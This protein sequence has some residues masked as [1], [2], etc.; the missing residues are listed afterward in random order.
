MEL[1]TEITKKQQ[2]AAYPLNSVW[3]S[4]SAGSGKTKVLTDRVLNLLLQGSEPERLLCL[5]FTKAAA[6]EMANRITATLKKWA[7]ADDEELEKLL[8][9]LKG[10]MPTKEMLKLARA[11]F[12]KVLETP[13]GL[14]IMTI[15]S[16]CQSV[17]KRFPIEA[18]IP[19]QFE[20]IEET[21]SHALMH[22][23]ISETFVH[24]KFKKKAM[25]L[26]DYF[27]EKSIK[28]IF[29]MILQNQSL[30]D[31][32]LSSFHEKN[33]LENQLKKYFQIEKYQTKKEIINK[34]F[35]IEEFFELKN[36]YLTKDE[37]ILKKH[38]EEDK[39]HLVY[40]INQ[41][42]KAFDL[43]NVTCAITDIIA[44]I[45]KRY[46]KLKK[47]DSLLD[48]SDLI[49]LTRD[50]L[51]KSGMSQWV[52]YKLDGGIDHIL[53]DEAQDTN[54]EQWEIVRLI[55]EEFFSGLGSR[56]DLVR[57]IFAVGD[58][59]Q[60]IYSFQGADPNE[61][62]RMHQFF[63]QQ[64]KRSEKNFETVPLNVSFRSTA[65]VLDLVNL[66]LKNKKIKK[67][68]LNE[69]EE[70]VHTPFRSKDGG[71]VE[72]WPLEEGQEKESLINWSFPEPNKTPASATKLAQRIADKIS[73]MIGKEILPSRGTPIQAGDIMILVRSRNKIVSELVRALKERNIPVAGVDRIILTEHIAVQDL[74]CVARFALLPEDDL[75][76]ACLLKSPLFKLSEEDLFKL[77]HYR[78]DL[79]LYQQV[80]KEKQDI[81]QKLSLILNQADKMPV[82][83]FFS[84]LLGPL[85]GR[86]A[87]V[88][89]L[90]TEANEALDEFLSLTLHFEE[91]EIPTLQNFLKWISNRKVEIKRDLDQS[92]IDAVRIMTVHAS[93]GLQGNIVFLPDTRGVPKSKDTFLWTD[94]Q[95]PLWIA[96]AALKTNEVERLYEKLDE[97]EIEESNRLLYVALTRAKDRLYICGWDNKKKK[98]QTFTHNW[99]DL[100]CSSLPPEIK[101]DEDKIIRIFS[102]QLKEAEGEENQER[103]NKKTE[104]PAFVFKEAPL[105]T[106]LSKPLMPSQMED[107]VVETDTVLGLDRAKAMKRGTFIHQLLQYLPDIEP[108]KRKEVALRLKPDGIDIPENLFDVF[109]KEEF[110]HLFS[111]ESKAEVPIVGVVKNQVVSGQID[112]LIITDDAVLIVDFK[113]GKHVPLRE[114]FVPPLYIKQMMMYKELLKEIFP[115]KMIKTYLLWTENLSLMEL[116]KHDL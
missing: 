114:E 72:I 74:I 52:L 83:E 58:K 75:N 109:E 9:N 7:I 44:H 37:T 98:K 8:F 50:L 112:R 66:I 111:K 86:K 34:Y 51:K 43:V 54:P 32:R 6:A 91:T 93:K 4:A 33:N 104:L 12:V 106:A 25:L 20:V 17:L 45:L 26:S 69:N 40:E 68:L 23:A 101:P 90:G 31:E 21:K 3:V 36:K 29:D 65:A 5:T 84:Y 89:R 16:F 30:L 14:K 62:E 38:Q 48:Y 10:V 46:K 113:S 79:S 97:L 78:K 107:E 24:P 28:G 96:A 47:E 94:T 85:K 71:L 11:L 70:A 77:A 60:S 59:K 110:N 49:S 108:E 39:A 13:G 57:T 116:T 27:Y 22:Q 19:P 61:F 87:F 100:I 53:I 63:E 82:F 115:D 41:R 35:E 2:T 81:A 80:I 99:Y 76:L 1:L 67:G 105:E 18:S 92:G 55:A 42:L 56:P 88:E 64:V 15:H 73:K 103:I 102:P 95:L